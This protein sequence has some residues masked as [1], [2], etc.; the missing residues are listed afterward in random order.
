MLGISILIILDI[1]MVA[2][3]VPKMN[4]IILGRRFKVFQVAARHCT[5]DIWSLVPNFYY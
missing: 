2:V 4:N 5:W 1:G 3:F